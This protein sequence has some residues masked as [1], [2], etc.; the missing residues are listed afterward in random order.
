MIKARFN[1]AICYLRLGKLSEARQDYEQLLKEARLPVPIWAV[2][3]GLGEIAFR[4]GDLTVAKN[5][6]ERYLKTAPQGT[7]EFR[8]V[9]MRLEEIRKK[10]GS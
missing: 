2:Y 4:T 1:R 8:K 9:E 3:Y 7:E 5:Y 10:A 6:Y